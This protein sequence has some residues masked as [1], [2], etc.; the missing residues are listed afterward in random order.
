MLCLWKEVLLFNDFDLEVTVSGWYPEGETKSLWIVSA[1]MGY[2]IPEMGKTVLFTAYQSIFSPTLNHNF[3]S[4][5]QMRLHDMVVNETPKCQC[6]K[7]TNLSHSISM[8]GDNVDDVLVIPLE[9]SNHPKKNLKP[10]RGTN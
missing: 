10:V 9:L 5:M 7:P 8:R 6:L 4:T 3:L 2:T 1:S